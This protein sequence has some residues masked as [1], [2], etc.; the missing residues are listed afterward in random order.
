MNFAKVKQGPNAGEFVRYTISKDS[1]SCWI[2]PLDW[3]KRGLSYTASGYGKKIPTHYLVR[4][5]NQK[6]RR[7]YCAIFSNV[8]TYYVVENGENVIVDIV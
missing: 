6:W 3:Q 4:T 1:P 2:K 8:G 7:V 5:I